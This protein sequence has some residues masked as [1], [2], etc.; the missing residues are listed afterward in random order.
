M[1]NLE[2]I[3]SEIKP[4]AEPLMFQLREFIPEQPGDAYMSRSIGCAGKEDGYDD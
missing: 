1:G 2:Q 4:A 3:K